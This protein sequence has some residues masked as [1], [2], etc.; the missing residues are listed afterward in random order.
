MLT[1]L[2]MTVLLAT[3]APPEPPADLVLLSAKIWTGDPK[4]PEAEALA[5]RDGRIVAVGMDSD[6]GKLKGPKTVVIDGKWR[7]VVPGFIDCHTHMTSGG[8]DLLALD[9]RTRRIRRRV[10]AHAWPSTRRRAGGGVADRR[11][12]GRQ[13]VD[14]AASC[15][16]RRFSI[17]R[18]ATIR[19]A[20]RARTAT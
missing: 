10:H 2:A 1:A 9:L 20:S 7:R 16:P 19:R 8:F 15:R 14:A 5:V 13:A 12:L 4:N 6:I 17:P 3:T 18:P 11:R